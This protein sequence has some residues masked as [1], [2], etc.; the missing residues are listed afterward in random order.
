MKTLHEILSDAATEEE[1]KNFFAKFFKL[2]LSTKNFIDLYT[3]QILFEFKFDAPI[4]NIQT[5]AA[6]VAQTLYYIRRLK[7]GS[8]IRTPSKNICVVTKYAAIF[9]PTDNFSAFIRRKSYDWDLAP[10]SPCKKLVADLADFAPV[11]S[12]HVYDFS[13]AEDE[14]NFI[15][16]IKRN[17][18]EQLSLFGE[19]K[20]INENNFYPIFELW[21]KIFGAAVE[22]GRKASEYFI[23]DIEE[24]KSQLIG[25]SVLFRMSGGELIEKFLNA[26]EYKHFWSVYEKITNPRAVIAIR[27]KMDRMSEI[28][29]RRFTGEFFTPIAFAEKAVEYLRRTVDFTSGK[30]RIWDMAAGTGNLEFAL[31][32]EV[33]KYCYISTLL[34]DDADYCK[35]IFPDATVFQYDYLND[36]VNFFGN[37][38]VLE[39]LGIKK[40]MPARLA[41]DLK[42]PDLHW[43]I[44]INPP[45]ATASNF[46]R[47][48]NR[49]DKDGVSMTEIRKLMN[50]EKLGKSSRELYIQ[51]LYRINREF[52]NKKAYLGIFS[53]PKYINANNDQPFRDK[54]FNY[55]F[56]RGFILSSQNFEGCK[57]KFPISFMVWNLKERIPVEEQEIILDIYD[58]LVE[59][60]AEKI[61]RPAR[62]E[63]F[64]NKWVK[65]PTNTKKFPPMSSGLKFAFNNKISCDKVP[66]GFLASLMCWNDFLHQNY[67]AILSAPYGTAGGMSITAENFE[68]YMIMHA[69]HLIPKL[70]WKNNRDQFMQPSKPLTREFITDAVIWSL[71]A[72]SNQTV[73]LRNV[74]YEGEFYRIKNNFFPFLLSEI[75]DWECSSPEIRMQIAL[76]AED[77][78]AATWIKN[79]PLSAQS[80]DVLD[81]GRMIYKKFY[82]ELS[83]LDTE[84]FKIEDWDAGWYQIRMSLGASINLSELSAK[85]EPQIYRAVYRCFGRGADDLQEILCGTFATRHRKI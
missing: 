31:P 41:N 65:R 55:K 77:R 29:L 57:G 59:K 80:I 14:K 61:F 39:N 12:C 52:F 69:V 54:V 60:Y 25:Q 15:E 49:Q 27:Q 11:K 84:K 40:K 51:F 58:S 33:L 22:N 30:Y 50:A 10:S 75:R 45:Y 67:T 19:R 66:D 5:R 17:L 24:G 64:L 2:K 20:E 32:A 81:A 38:L 78:F 37:E 44:F 1:L 42:N 68:Q 56:E 7:F 53:T 28:S 26:D 70:D 73:S 62:S 8:D 13:T 46:E 72:P 74:E 79:N 4:N 35:K 36:D 82:A 6:A 18:V 3:A 48:E 76:A 83:Q 71:F 85:L 16:L 34:Q 23:T 9:F 47:K 43:I 63:E 21:Q